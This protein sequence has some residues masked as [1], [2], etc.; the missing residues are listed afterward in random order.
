MFSQFFKFIMLMKKKLFKIILSNIHNWKSINYHGIFCGMLTPGKWSLTCLH[1]SNIPTL[2]IKETTKFVKPARNQ[3]SGFETY[4]TIICNN[5]VV[6][7]LI[8]EICWIIFITYRLELKENFP[9]NPINQALSGTN[10]DLLK[11]AFISGPF[12]WFSIA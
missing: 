3:I 7:M 10:F 12:Y 6:S 9:R 5:V 2:P 8:R 1:V 11:K 4:L